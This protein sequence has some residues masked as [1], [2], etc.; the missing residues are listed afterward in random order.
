M[1][2][3]MPDLEACNDNESNIAGYATLMPLRPWV[4]PRSTDDQSNREVCKLATGV[5]LQ[6][7]EA[8]FR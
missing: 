1:G 5:W 2:R 6:Y 4:W 3:T 7:G 8:Q